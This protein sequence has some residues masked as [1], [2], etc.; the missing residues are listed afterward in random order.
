MHEVIAHDSFEGE[1][2]VEVVVLGRES[3]V[4]LADQISVMGNGKT[5]QKKRTNCQQ[6]NRT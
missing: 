2:E 1:V 3:R 4:C 6:S 5:K